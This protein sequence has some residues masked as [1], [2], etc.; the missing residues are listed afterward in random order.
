MKII[1]ND[2]LPAAGR[3][4]DATPAASNL[5]RQMEGWKP[6]NA[7]GVNNGPTSGEQ[8]ITTKVEQLT[9]PF[10]SLAQPPSSI[11]TSATAARRNVSDFQ[12]DDEMA[13]GG[14]RP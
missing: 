9:P 10:R 5:G 4:T 2:S 13:G 14:G 1:P 8:S 6:S 11:D 3:A 12:A 7:A